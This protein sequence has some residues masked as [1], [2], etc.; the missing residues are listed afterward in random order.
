MLALLLDLHDSCT[1]VH[2]D[3]TAIEDARSRLDETLTQFKGQ[4]SR[5]AR[6]L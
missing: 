3:M 1:I 6:S 4:P 2:E 5:S